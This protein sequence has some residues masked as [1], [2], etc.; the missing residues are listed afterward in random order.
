MKEIQSSNYLLPNWTNFI[1]SFNVNVDVKVNF[2]L[3]THHL[4]SFQLPTSILQTFNLP[5]SLFP[6][7]SFNPSIHQSFNLSILLSFNLSIFQSFY[8]NSS[9]L[10]PH[11]S[12]PNQLLHL[13]NKRI[14]SIIGKSF[15]S[16]TNH[17]YFIQNHRGRQATCINGIW[18]ETIRLMEGNGKPFFS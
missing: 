16:V 3:S 8:P 12:F 13:S 10:I 2:N 11:S 14:R 7:P 6:L 15:M 1:K 18:N 5:S 9:F 17:T 4:Q